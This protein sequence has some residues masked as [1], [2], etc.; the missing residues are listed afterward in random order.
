[1]T[2]IGGD[3]VAEIVD[4]TVTHNPFTN[5]WRLTFQVRPKK[6]EPIELRAFLDMGGETL[7]ETWSSVILP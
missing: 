6:R 4:Q 2:V 3:D 1:V 7:T 5:G